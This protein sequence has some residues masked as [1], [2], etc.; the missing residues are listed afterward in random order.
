MDVHLLLLF[1]SDWA[2]CHTWKC[3]ILKNVMLIFTDFDKFDIT[4]AN[5]FLFCLVACVGDGGSI[6]IH[7]Y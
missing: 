2:L 6:Y 5:F 7:L 1:G 4:A 3:M